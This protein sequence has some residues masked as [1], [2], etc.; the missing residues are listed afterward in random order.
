MELLLVIMLLYKLGWVDD[1]YRC[2][3]V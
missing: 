3:S 1:V 2:I